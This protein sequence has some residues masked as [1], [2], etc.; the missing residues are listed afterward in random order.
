MISFSGRKV[1]V[2]LTGAFVEAMRQMNE[3]EGR[4]DLSFFKKRR[5]EEMKLKQVYARG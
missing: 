2:S 4:E 1:N 3:Y 5:C